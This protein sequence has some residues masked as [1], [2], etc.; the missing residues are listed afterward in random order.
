MAA[1]GV[2]SNVDSLPSEGLL[3]VPQ[4]PREIAIARAESKR[5]ESTKGRAAGLDCSEWI[6]LGR[7]GIG[8]RS[9]K[10]ETKLRNPSAVG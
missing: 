8:I 2:E 3:G 5:V 9:F 6:G 7:M 1:V 4:E 10:I